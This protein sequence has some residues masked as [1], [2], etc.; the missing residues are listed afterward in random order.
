MTVA[1]T[2]RHERA[3]EALRP[4]WGERFVT[5]F[6]QQAR[7]AKVAEAEAEQHVRRQV[8]RKITGLRNMA[9]LV[10]ATA[11]AM[12]SAQH[13]Q[14]GLL[15]GV[16]AGLGAGMSAASTVH[17]QHST[18]PLRRQ[19]PDAWEG[20]PAVR[21]GRLTLVG[22]ADGR[23]PCHAVL[24]LRG[25]T[26]WLVLHDRASPEARAVRAS[27]AAELESAKVNG[28]SLGHFA[29]ELDFGAEAE[30]ERGAG[31][32]RP[33]A[34][35]HLYEQ[36]LDAVAV[37]LVRLGAV[38]RVGLPVAALREDAQLRRAGFAERATALRKALGAAAPPPFV[39]E[40]GSHRVLSMLGMAA[41]ERAAD[42]AHA[43]DFRSHQVRPRGQYVACHAD[44][45]PRLAREAVHLF[46]S[47]DNAATHCTPQWI[48]PHLLA[49]FVTGGGT[50]GTLPPPRVS[51][52]PGL[53]TA[54]FR[55]QTGAARGADA[56]DVGGGA[57]GSVAAAV[58][59]TSI[60][61]KMH[62]AHL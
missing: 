45:R 37:E 15:S 4:L 29:A 11:R 50:R 32:A 47:S 25:K 27:A 3:R 49:R 46:V 54:D 23:L 30:L 43:A 52:G 62:P 56:R 26:G 61:F 59:E 40:G 58:S 6:G 7:R 24:K 16:V 5:V 10:G 1:S 34:A 55:G 57:P 41:G 20:L 2:A 28:L 39:G 44:R 19:L 60:P 53:I 13:Q 22:G 14:G 48:R 18:D 31:G 8:K 17:K 35:L 9:D 38:D 21:E 36:A 42:A 12:N 51:M 33:L